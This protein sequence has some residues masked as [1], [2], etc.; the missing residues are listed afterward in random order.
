MLVLF[1]IKVVFFGNYENKNCRDENF[2]ITTVLI[3]L[4]SVYLHNEKAPDSRNLIF[5]RNR[6]LQIGSGRFL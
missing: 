6:I 5:S 4:L 3:N 1:F 2:F